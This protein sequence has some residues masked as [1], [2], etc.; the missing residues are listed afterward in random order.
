MPT[1]MPQFGQ[2]TE[3]N[4]ET[5]EYTNLRQV[6]S[7]SSHLLMV[8]RRSPIP[9]GF[10]PSA[11]YVKPETAKPVQEQMTTETTSVTEDDD[12]PDMS[13]GATIA[14]GGNLIGGKGDR[15]SKKICLRVNLEDRRLG[16]N[17]GRSYAMS[18]F[19]PGQQNIP[20]GGFA[21]ITNITL[22]RPEGVY[23]GKGQPLGNKVRMDADIFNK[24]M[25][26]DGL[27]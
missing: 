12:K 15:H 5:R 9:P 18:T 25:A 24:Y 20:E 16:I 7:G 17:E 13:T 3:Q 2:F 6:R 8:S 23:S 26:G 11:E 22:P 1:Q 10:V 14:F 4:V 27:K 19:A 21:T